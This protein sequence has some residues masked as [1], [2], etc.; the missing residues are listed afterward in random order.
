MAIIKKNT[1]GEYILGRVEIR[2][3][4]DD[5]IDYIRMRLSSDPHRPMPKTLDKLM[6]EYRKDIIFYGKEYV[7]RYR[8][9]SKKIEEDHMIKSMKLTRKYF[10][11]AKIEG[12]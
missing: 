6:Y 10:S 12:G 3:R 11:N 7:R 9:V 8:S 5:V 4:P 1:R 2:I